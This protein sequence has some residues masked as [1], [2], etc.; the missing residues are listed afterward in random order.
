MITIKFQSGE[1]KRFKAD[2][3]VVKDGFLEL[4]VYTKDRTKLQ[5]GRSFP[6]NTVRCAFLDNGTYVIG[7]LETRYD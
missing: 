1:Q 2:S 7:S 5:A 6:T 4:Y 3:A